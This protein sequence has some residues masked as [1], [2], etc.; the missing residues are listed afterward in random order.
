MPINPQIP[1]SVRTPSQQNLLFEQGRRVQQQNQLFDLTRDDLAAQP[2]LANQ[3]S[4]LNL[5]IGEQ[6]LQTGEQ[7]LQLG[8]VKLSQAELINT[9]DTAAEV[10]A[11]WR[12]NDTRAIDWVANWANS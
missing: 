9:F 10:E 4:E 8:D 5:R 3:T 12:I 1:L 2:G 7:N 6:G 11:L